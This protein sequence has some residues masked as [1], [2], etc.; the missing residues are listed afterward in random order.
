MDAFEVDG[1]HM[2]PFDAFLDAYEVHNH[3]EEVVD[4]VPW[5]YVGL[6]DTGLE[7]LK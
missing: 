2:D 4:L 6:Q 7:L 3:E 5:A 1:V